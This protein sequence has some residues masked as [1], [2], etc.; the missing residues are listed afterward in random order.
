MRD[1]PNHSSFTKYQHG[2]LCGIIRS[3][4]LTELES[5]PSWGFHFL[6]IGDVNF[7]YLT[8]TCNNSM[9]AEESRIQHEIFAE[10]IEID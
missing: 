2:V 6:K 3:P 9:Q 4:V 5:Q 1:Y 7:V 10:F 8:D